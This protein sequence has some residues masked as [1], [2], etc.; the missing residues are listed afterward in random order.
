MRNNNAHV[1][2]HTEVPRSRSEAAAQRAAASWEKKRLAISLC[3]NEGGKQKR[4]K[5]INDQKTG[6]L[7][8]LKNLLS[9]GQ[10]SVK[11]KEVFSSDP[12]QSKLRPTQHYEAKARA[13]FR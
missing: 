7:C 4:K 6:K 8:K 12:Q 9:Q 11:K 10:Q 3:V 13:Q 2:K 1:Q 5:G